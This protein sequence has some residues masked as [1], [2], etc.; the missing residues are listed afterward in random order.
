MPST[1]SNKSSKST[2]SS[3]T[4]FLVLQNPPT[5]SV[6]TNIVRIWNSNKDLSKKP[7]EFRSSLEAWRIFVS[8][9]RQH[10]FIVPKNN[11][12]GGSNNNS[13]NAP[14]Y[15]NI[16]KSEVLK[17]QLRLILFGTIPQLSSSDH[18]ERNNNNNNNNSPYPYQNDP[19]AST[20]YLPQYHQQQ[21]RQEASRSS[22]SLSS[23][24]E[25][26]CLLALDLGTLFNDLRILDLRNIFF[27]IP[28]AAEERSID[29]ILGKCHSN[30]LPASLGHLYLLNCTFPDIG[31]FLH[32]QQRENRRKLK[33]QARRS[34]A[35]AG[36]AR[37]ASSSSASPSSSSSDYNSD[38]EDDS[39]YHKITYNKKKNKNNKKK[40]SNHHHHH[41]TSDQQ[42]AFDPESAL[43]QMLLKGI[44]AAQLSPLMPF[45]ALGHFG[46]ALRHLRVVGDEDKLRSVLKPHHLA[47][48]SLHLQELEIA[49]QIDVAQHQAELASEQSLA[50]QIMAQ[51]KQ[52][53]ISK[54]PN[55]HGKTSFESLVVQ[56]QQQQQQQQDGNTLQSASNVFNPDSHQNDPD[57]LL[58]DG[59]SGKKQNVDNNDSED[60]FDHDL[61]SKQHANFNRIRTPVTNSNDNNNN[62][63]NGQFPSVQSLP[64]SNN[65][66]DDN[67]NNVPTQ[68][69]DDNHNNN[70]PLAQR[71]SA[72]ASIVRKPVEVPLARAGALAQS[73]HL[74]FI[75]RGAP[76]QSEYQQQHSTNSLH[77][78]ATS[79]QPVLSFEPEKTHDGETAATNQQQQQ[80]QQQRYQNQLLLKQTNKRPMW[81]LLSKL[82]IRGLRWRHVAP[83]IGTLPSLT[84]LDL[85]YNHITS[86]LVPFAVL[87]QNP[88]LA[89]INLAFNR[90]KHIGNGSDAG[91]PSSVTHLDLSHNSLESFNHGQPLGL[92]VLVALREIDLSYNKL[93]YWSDFHALI[94]KSWTLRKVRIDHNP[95]WY[96][97]TA[98][99]TLF[100]TEAPKFTANQLAMLLLAYTDPA[101]PSLETNGIYYRRS[102]IEMKKVIP[103]SK[104]HAPLL[105]KLP[106]IFD[107]KRRRQMM[108]TM[109]SNKKNR[110]SVSAVSSNTPPPSQRF[111]ANH[112]HVVCFVDSNNNNTQHL[113]D[114]NSSNLN[115]GSS[116][117]SSTNHRVVIRKTTRRVVRHHHSKRKSHAEDENDEEANAT[118][119]EDKNKEPQQQNIDHH[120]KDKSIETQPP[121][122][123]GFVASALDNNNQSQ[124]KQNKE[125]S[126]SDDDGQEPIAPPSLPGSA[127]KHTEEEDSNK[128]KSQQQPI[129]KEEK[130][131]QQKLQQQRSEE[132]KKKRQEAEANR[133]KRRELAE[134]FAK[135]DPSI[136]KLIERLTHFCC[137]ED[138][139]DDEEEH[140]SKSTA[141]LIS[142]NR[143]QAFAHPPLDSHIGSCLIEI[144]Y[145]TM[146]HRLRHRRNV[147]DLSSSSSDD[148][149][150]HSH[151]RHHHNEAKDDRITSYTD[152]VTLFAISVIEQTQHWQVSLLRRDDLASELPIH[153]R[154]LAL[155]Q[156]LLHQCTSTIPSANLVGLNNRRRQM[157][158]VVSSFHVSDCLANGSFVKH[159]A[160]E[161]IVVTHDE[162][163][164]PADQQHDKNNNQHPAAAASG[165]AT[166]NQTRRRL[167][168][169][170]VLSGDTR[171]AAY[172][173]CSGSPQE[174]DNVSRFLQNDIRN[175]CSDH[176]DPGT[177]L[178]VAAGGRR[179]WVISTV[180]NLFHKGAVDG[181]SSEFF[182]QHL[183]RKELM[184]A[185]PNCNKKIKSD[186]SSHYSTRLPTLSKIHFEADD[187]SSSAKKTHHHHHTHEYVT[188]DRVI[189]RLC[190]YDFGSSL[191]GL[192]HTVLDQAVSVYASCKCLA[193]EESKEQIFSSL[194][195]S[196][197]SSTNTSNSTTQQ[198]QQKHLVQ[199]TALIHS[200]HCWAEFTADRVLR[201]VPQNKHVL[202]SHRSNVPSPKNAWLCDEC[203]TKHTCWWSVDI[204]SSTL[205][206]VEVSADLSF[207]TLFSINVVNSQERQSVCLRTNNATATATLLWQ[208]RNVM[209]P[210]T[211][212]VR[213][214]P[215]HIYLPKVI[216]PSSSSS[217]P[218]SN[219]GSASATP[220]TSPRH[221]Q[222][223]QNYNKDSNATTMPILIGESLIQKTDLFQQ[224]P[225][226]W[227][228]IIVD[229]LELVH[230]EG[231]ALSIVEPSFLA[232]D[233]NKKSKEGNDG[234]TTT[235]SKDQQHPQNQ[236]ATS[237]TIV[238][239]IYNTLYD[240]T[241]AS[242]KYFIKDDRQ[243]T[244]QQHQQ[245]HD[246]FAALADQVRK[247]AETEEDEYGNEVDPTEA[248]KSTAAYL[249]EQPKHLVSAV[250]SIASSTSRFFTSSW[251]G[252]HH[253]EDPQSSEHKQGTTTA[254]TVAPASHSSFTNFFW[255]GGGSGTANASANQQQQSSTTT[256]NNNSNILLSRT[257]SQPDWLP[258][259]APGK[260]AWSGGFFAEIMIPVHCGGENDMTKDFDVKPSSSNQ[261]WIPALAF[262]VDTHGREHENGSGNNESN[263]T[264]TAVEQKDTG[265]ASNNNK[266]QA[267]PSSSSTSLPESPLSSATYGGLSR[268]EAV[269][270]AI[271]TREDI[272]FIEVPTS[273]R[274]TKRQRRRGSSVRT[275]TTATTQNSD[276][277]DDDKN[278]TTSSHH[279]DDTTT[280]TTTTTRTAPLSRAATAP[281]VFI[282]KARVIPSTKIAQSLF[283]S[284][285]MLFC[286]A[287]QQR[288][289][290]LRMLQ[291]VVGNNDTDDQ[292]SK[293]KNDDD[294]AA[295]MLP[296]IE[297]DIALNVVSVSNWEKRLPS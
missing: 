204:L 207:I 127:R 49:T 16:L 292:E 177:T 148:N 38:D 236:T 293:N 168:W 172:V 265:D 206:H 40:K 174:I 104:V 253:H 103:L 48:V 224:H 260:M 136:H 12:N 239:S 173:L 182:K 101:C 159:L 15:I 24:N 90:L 235:S 238:G 55:Q 122:T 19:R 45:V 240:F 203:R 186:S 213:V 250:T 2:P 81:P 197:S 3:A 152:C 218:Q 42:H 71:R 268:R 191:P 77:N 84:H 113:N 94:H 25:I 65:D 134:R 288:S 246:G 98:T 74:D 282:M 110:S 267:S 151:H 139:D 7:R 32:K 273:G 34:A 85:A 89:Y 278:E 194:F 41:E 56:Q 196:S 147:S 137:G 29:Y 116:N 261:K 234:A 143:A 205:S 6:L 100:G 297:N 181:F 202:R 11:R 61:F 57:V 188:F 222:Q 70:D 244:E 37:R 79:S 106:P 53:D 69:N 237:T 63:N 231:C 17:N 128:T 92:P 105:L 185:Q 211:L 43:S 26:T 284:N 108:A 290:Y 276:N 183:V 9:Y 270:A 153:N 252:R 135:L 251:T 117:M 283:G 195:F 82:I 35:G 158:K 114:T 287:A 170:P 141:G 60:D 175:C 54:I 220:K 257:Y 145:P 112:P 179:P 215:V 93:A 219:A 289:S 190:P 241:A 286:L 4:P 255:G 51:Q 142:A 58:D 140:H 208:L 200:Y 217:A 73:I 121:R 99:S 155:E 163:S 126:D 294:V 10:L 291:N 83:V 76:R 275:S 86:L 230:I 272:S 192:V 210:T 160:G 249:L 1:T 167:I 214:V 280:T 232:E 263:N 23:S 221:Q 118:V 107:V 133:R 146:A 80:Q 266:K 102:E 285:D 189:D 184:E 109:V 201:L 154:D 68:Q 209:H 245:L 264:E 227:T 96:E 78:L 254:T 18:Q 247:N 130:E 295:A 21:Q 157:W 111:L 30:A 180:A 33:L 47:C 75:R 20:A 279:T 88:H 169:H 31:A 115:D 269:L 277:E 125:A 52:V 271:L 162:R 138:D 97:A 156:H 120:E 256:H 166:E 8:Q 87:A 193:F 161:E 281:L 39:V 150:D 226:D 243:A 259:D 59:S 176:D 123:A 274:E 44:S 62:N 228:K 14:F 36:G 124:D 178:A 223:Q 129:S 144:L 149:D 67:N 171:V 50:D 22:V 91:L 225:Q 296:V 248:T 242:A 27:R 164:H 258:F 216:T 72:S 64:N 13:S 119:E 131:K 132:Q 66:N 229:Q 165:A 5:D 198:Q 199:Q 187:G 233:E 262:I 28:N 46:K 212:Q 95:L